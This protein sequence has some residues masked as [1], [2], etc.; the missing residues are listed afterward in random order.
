MP[1]FSK[2]YGLRP[3]GHHRDFS[4]LPSSAS[5][6]QV[7]LTLLYFLFNSLFT[8]QLLKR[9]VGPVQRRTSPTPGHKTKRPPALVTLPVPAIPLRCPDRHRLDAPALAGLAI[10]LIN[11]NIILLH[12][13]SQQ[14]RDD[15]CCESS[16]VIY[17]ARL[18]Y[19]K[20]LLEIA[21]EHSSKRRTVHMIR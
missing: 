4:P 20:S 14:L 17:T 19:T 15:K 16:R 18:S 11:S 6:S 13:F 2:C 7:L 5:L 9:R 3:T 1:R 8:Y 12:F 21:H 10:N